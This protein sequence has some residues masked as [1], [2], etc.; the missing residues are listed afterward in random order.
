MYSVD[1]YAKIV[2][3]G[4]VEGWSEREVVRVFGFHRNTVRKMLRFSVLPGYRR[5]VPAVSPK[6]GSYTEI[7][8]EILEA[9]RH[10]HKKQR[11]CWGRSGFW[12]IG[13]QS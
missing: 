6:L 5:K 12:T 7:I 13:R 2:R 1:L 10:V 11:L 9:D 3:L 8:D 4:M